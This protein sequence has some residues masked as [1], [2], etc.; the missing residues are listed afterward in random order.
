MKHSTLSIAVAGLAVAAFAL[1]LALPFKA[2]AGPIL[3]VASVAFIVLILRHDY[4][5]RR[6]SAPT[7]RERLPYAA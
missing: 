3:L 2:L 5:A 7:R 6:P 1:A 4:A